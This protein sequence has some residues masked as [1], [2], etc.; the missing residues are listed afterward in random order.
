M[1]ETV[2]LVANDGHGLSAYVARPAGTPKGAIVVVQEIFGI[3]AHIRNVV[4][5]YAKEGYTVI[6]PALFDRYERGVELSYGGEDG[7]KAFE[8]YAKLSPETALLD[9]D[10][11]S[12][13]LT[14]DGAKKVGVIGFCFG[15]LMAWISATRGKTVGMVPACC[16]GYYAGGVGNVA[17]EQPACPVMLHFGGADSHIGPE[18]REAVVKAHP[19]V[20]VFVYE[21][22]EHGF[23]RD[24]WTSYNPEAAKL[25]RERTLEF[26]KKNL[27]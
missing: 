17:T 20:Q 12:R 23:N 18:Q 9:I 27:Q 19:E 22:A 16:V 3:N 24:V 10:S 26:L 21:G 6:A 25:A 4:D 1:S 11:A 13:F 2:K 7:K 8:L 5:G 14:S 15:G